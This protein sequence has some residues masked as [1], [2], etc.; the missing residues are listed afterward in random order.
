MQELMA[1]PSE[2]QRPSRAD[3]RITDYL[4]YDE[5]EALRHLCRLLLDTVSAVKGAQG[6]LDDSA[7]LLRKATEAHATAAVAVQRTAELV[8][9]LV[10]VTTWLDARR[11]LMRAGVAQRGINEGSPP[12]HKIQPS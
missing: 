5:R 10:A 7:A 2:P 11:E 3:A 1:D 12:Q 4:P 8:G 9:R 6:S